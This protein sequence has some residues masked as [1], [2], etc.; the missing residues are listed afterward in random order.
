MPDLHNLTIACHHEAGHACSYLF[1]R[2]RFQTVEVEQDDEGHVRGTVR[3]LAGRYDPLQR[4]IACLAGPLAEEKLTGVA[5]HKQPLSQTDLRMAQDD[6]QR[7]VPYR[8]LQNVADFTWTLV[9]Y[10]GPRSSASPTRC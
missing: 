6:L 3:I 4:A 8:D 10:A 9:E 2:W 7:A 5:W 1:F